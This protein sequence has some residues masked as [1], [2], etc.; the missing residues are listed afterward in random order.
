LFELQP[1]PEI[2]RRTEFRRTPTCA[3]PTFTPIAYCHNNKKASKQSILD[4]KSA[5]FHEPAALCENA[6]KLKSI[7]KKVM[8]WTHPCT[9]KQRELWGSGAPA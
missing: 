1:N 7:G 4:N 6:R 8:R 5:E 3:A 2:A 9:G